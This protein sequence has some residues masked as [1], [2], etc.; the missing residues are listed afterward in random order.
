M[1]LNVVSTSMIRV[2]VLSL[3][4]SAGGSIFLAKH[5]ID[6]HEQFAKELQ[7]VYVVPPT[8]KPAVTQESIDI[9]IELFEIKIPRTASRPH[10]DMSLEDRGLTTLNGWGSKLEVTIGPAAFSSWALLGSTLAHELEIHCNQNFALIR[11]KDVMGLEGTQEAE[12]EAYLHEL[13]NS[14]RFHLK[15]ADQ[16]NIKAT[17]DYYYPATIRAEDRLTARR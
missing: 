12:R 10:L 6:Q 2:F 9:A 7:S 16:M 5:R 15:T 8:S 17:M 3:V 11:M 14:E 1:L 4:F 13:A